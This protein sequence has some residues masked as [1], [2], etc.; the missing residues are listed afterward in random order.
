VKNSRL[1]RGVVFLVLVLLIALVTV[2]ACR[3]PENTPESTPGVEIANPAAV[4]CIEQGYKNEIRTDAEGNQYG[5]CIMDDGTECDEWVFYRGECGPGA[6]PTPA[7]A[8]D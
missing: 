8:S 6:T 3:T 2:V 7:P 4:Y 1:I 5:V